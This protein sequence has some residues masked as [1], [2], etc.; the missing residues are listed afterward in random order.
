MTKSRNG[1]PA[2]KG[3]TKNYK[4][5]SQEFCDSII[6][7]SKGNGEKI[8]NN[9]LDDPKNKYITLY[10]SDKSAHI[11][12]EY[13]GGSNTVTGFRVNTKD[14][15]YIIDNSKKLFDIVVELLHFGFSYS[16][17]KTLTNINHK[18]YEVCKPKDFATMG[19]FIF[20][21]SLVPKNL[22]RCNDILHYVKD[23]PAMVIEYP[24]VSALSI[25]MGITKN[26]AKKCIDLYNSKKYILLMNTTRKKLE[27]EK[28]N[29]ENIV[30][31]AS[32]TSVETNHIEVEHTDIV[33]IVEMT[34]EVISE[35]VSDIEPVEES[36]SESISE[37]ISE[38]ISEP[39]S[40]VVS[41]PSSVNENIENSDIIE[42]EQSA[43]VNEVEESDVDEIEEVDDNTINDEDGVVIKRIRKSEP[44]TITDYQ[45]QLGFMGIPFDFDLMTKEIK[46]AMLN[47]TFGEYISESNKE[48]IS[49]LLYPL[50]YLNHCYS[51][52][53]P[54]YP[55][56]DRILE[57]YYKDIGYRVSDIM[58]EVIPNYVKR[59]DY[60]Y[61][62]RIREKGY[63]TCN[64][65]IGFPMF[66]EDISLIHSL[67]KK[68]KKSPSKYFFWLDTFDLLYMAEKFGYC[69]NTSKKVKKV[70]DVINMDLKPYIEPAMK[71]KEVVN[72]SDFW[73][74]DKHDI[75]KEEFKNNGLSVLSL[76]PDLTK[77]E[78][79]EHARVYKINQ[80][81]TTK[82]VAEMREV[83]M[84]YGFEGLLEHFSYRTESALKF[85]VEEQNWEEERNAIL[86][87][88]EIE[89]RVAQRLDSLRESLKAELHAE[90]LSNEL[91]KYKESLKIEVMPIVRIDVVEELSAKIK[92]PVMQ[93][94]K[95]EM[96]DMVRKCALKDLPNVLPQ[97]IITKLDS[98][99]REE[100]GKLGQ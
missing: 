53:S 5:I 86:L 41:E 66:D 40:E 55:A 79:L 34:P 42:D 74:S 88:A 43:L 26:Q 22:Y 31:D 69:E 47:L 81:Y 7:K 45:T 9:L 21:L 50:V 100:V 92:G 58:A 12:R 65:D 59:P 51:Y 20:I 48:G 67:F 23:F 98:L 18:D 82:E 29:A 93:G 70:I 83:Y 89:N 35:N 10:N 46:N 33:D 52:S 28:K 68:V 62:Y 91:E 73:T 97:K 37:P 78:C 76:I 19:D 57:L 87:E 60:E 13:D 25:K 3:I 94:I 4:P 32:E 2:N 11:T 49:N 36:V 54:Y 95:F 14:D 39:I 61:L 90:V 63:K 27:D 38:S 24:S 1:R 72:H 15:S 17:I 99:M 84:K 6:N 8:T 16:Q 80:N 75:F 85:K 44:I 96:P 64:P 56:E 30:K 71:L 77:D